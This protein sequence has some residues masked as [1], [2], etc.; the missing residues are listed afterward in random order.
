MANVLQVVSRRQDDQ[1]HTK[2]LRYTVKEAHSQSSPMLTHSLSFSESDLIRP[3]LTF[4][5]NFDLS[6]GL[7]LAL[8]VSLRPW[9]R[10]RGGRGCG[11]VAAVRPFEVSFA[12]I[13]TSDSVY[14]NAVAGKRVGAVET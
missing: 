14:F 2:T 5:R 1:K 4:L 11:L 7:E 12:F 10:G 6:S 8:A 3:H 9:P 13:L